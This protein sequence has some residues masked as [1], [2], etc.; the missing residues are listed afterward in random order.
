VSH[1]VRH[2]LGA[3]YLVARAAPLG[4]ATDAGLGT[5]FHRDSSVTAAFCASVEN[6]S[7]F[8]LLFLSS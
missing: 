2:E 4:L 6:R 7:L 8:S 3:S 5:K 1:R